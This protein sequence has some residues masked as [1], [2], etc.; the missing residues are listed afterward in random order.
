MRKSR[1]ILGLRGETSSWSSAS[2]FPGQAEWSLWTAGRSQ[3]EAI[4]KHPPYKGRGRRQMAWEDRQPSWPAQYHTTQILKN[5][6]C[7]LSSMSKSEFPVSP[8]RK[9]R[10]CL[11]TWTYIVVKQPLMPLS[12]HDHPFSLVHTIPD[13]LSPSYF[14]PL[15]AP[16]PKSKPAPG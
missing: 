1:K 13:C 2:V 6:L 4:S 7:L 14:P 9:K 12:G 15:P 16:D 10:D 8:G 3:N 5:S 11:A